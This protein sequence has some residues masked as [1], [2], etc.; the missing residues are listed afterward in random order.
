MLDGF[1]AWPEDDTRRYRREGYWTDSVLGEIIDAWV[2]KEPDRVAVSSTKK[3]LTYGEIDVLATGFARGLQERGVRAGDS[4]VLQLPNIPEF[5]VVLLGLLRS[6]VRPVLAL[7]SHREFEIASFLQITGARTLISPTTY[8]G[9]DYAGMAARLDLDLSIVVGRA[10]PGHVLL[11]E[12]WADQGTLSRPDPSDVALFLLSG[13]T[14]GGPKLVPR[15]HRDYLY[16]IRCSAENAELGPSDVYLAALP[17]AHNYALAAP[18]VLGTLHT[19]GRVVMA[20]PSGAA[21]SFDLMTAERVT[22]TGLVPSMALLWTEHLSRSQQSL[23]RLRLMQVGG[24]KLEADN[25]RRLMDV[26]SCRLQQSFGMAEGLLSQSRPDDSM[27]TLATTQGKPISPADEVRVVDPHGVDVPPGQVGELL[28]RGPYTIRGYFRADEANRRSFTPDGFLRT[29]DLARLTDSGDLVIEGRIKDQ[30]NKG[31]EK[32]SATEI[33]D[34][35]AAHPGVLE[36][37]VVGV[38][39]RISGERIH[40]FVSPQGESVT[41]ADVV[42]FLRERNVANYKLPDVV[43]NVPEF[44]RTG[45]GKVDKRRLREGVMRS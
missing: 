42:T 1:V 33:E 30:I 27:E 44:P 25:A 45:A 34:L 21:E 31:G 26:F 19:G 23:P 37:A 8:L 20:P 39:E 13:G 11:D 29:G 43:H 41:T 36:C 3:R 4:V 24:D 32:V 22:V 38:P 16:N 2:V 28:T 40:V 9:F 10:R 14:T 12:V 35:L 15:T 6:G 17:V 18:G 5:I 7:P